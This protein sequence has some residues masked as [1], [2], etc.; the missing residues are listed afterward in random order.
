[1][2]HPFSVPFTSACVLCLV[3]QSCSALCNPVGGSLPGSSC[4]LG[5]FRQ[6]HWS[7]L[8]RSP[9]GNFL[10]QGPNPGLLH[11]R[12]ILYRL[13]P[14]GSPL[15][16]NVLNVQINQFLYHSPV[17]KCLVNA[18]SLGFKTWVRY[19][20]LENINLFSIK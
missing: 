16:P 12:R 17:G 2:V 19:L 3:L 14:Q 7:G 9:P 10:N 1:M 8:P 18:G 20:V 6:E 4:P 5:F 15:G 13:S 11:C